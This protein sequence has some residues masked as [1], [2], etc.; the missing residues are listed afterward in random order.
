MVGANADRTCSTRGPTKLKN[1][2]IIHTKWVLILA[3]PSDVNGDVCFLSD[4]RKVRAL[5]EVCDHSHD[6]DLP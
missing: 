6:L 2:A 1:Y 5:E 4:H 3:E